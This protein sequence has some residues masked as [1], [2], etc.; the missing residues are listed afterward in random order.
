MTEI[1]K[2][3]GGLAL[4]MKCRSRLRH[5]RGHGVHSPL[6]YS[7]IRN[8]FMNK[9]AGE[10]KYL[11]NKILEIGG[12]RKAARD[13]QN[14][15]DHFGFSTFSLNN[16]E[17]TFEGN[18]LYI[19]SDMLAGDSLLRT[20]DK[21]EMTGNALVVI[22]DKSKEL[23][24]LCKTIAEKHTGISIDRKDYFLYFYNGQY[25]KQHYKL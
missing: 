17:N 14:I 15:Y 12:S 11:H 13:A 5:R 2:R 24:S 7:L 16:I 20:I 3:A 1:K 10:D 9:G 21:G 18:R 6:V 4:H 8:V 25:A 22:P 23:K 19:F